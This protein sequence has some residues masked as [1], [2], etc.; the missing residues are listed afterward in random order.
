MKMPLLNITLFETDY[1]FW[2]KHYS[3][4]LNSTKNG[5]SATLQDLFLN[6]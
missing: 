3:R 5:Q 4:D 6:M 1:D 2:L